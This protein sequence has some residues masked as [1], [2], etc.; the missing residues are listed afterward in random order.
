MADELED[1]QVGDEVAV[2][3]RYNELSLAKIERKTTTQ[4]IV[5]GMRFY[6]KNGREVGGP[7]SWRHAWLSLVTNETREQI[8]AQEEIRKRVSI[9]EG[10][11]NCR[12]LRELSIDALTAIRKIIDDNIK[13]G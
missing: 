2:R 8:L 6:A 12:Q 10:I 11:R 9:A 7:S 1:L 4:L 5:G 3:S 13:E